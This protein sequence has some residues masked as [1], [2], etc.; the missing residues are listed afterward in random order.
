MKNI[1]RYSH[2]TFREQLPYLDNFK[3]LSYQFS[4]NKPVLCFLQS[5]LV[6]NPVNMITKT[7]LGEI[8]I[9]RLNLGKFR[10][11]ILYFSYFPYKHYKGQHAACYLLIIWESTRDLFLSLPSSPL[12]L[13]FADL[14]SSLLVFLI[15]NMRKYLLSW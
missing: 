12:S 9:I 1:S 8:E 3:L 14:L 5:L 7:C 13:L 10:K 15:R 4:C 2:M 11:L 6:R